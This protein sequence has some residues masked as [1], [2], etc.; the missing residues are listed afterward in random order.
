MTYTRTLIAVLAL[1]QIA[2]CGGSGGGSSDPAPLPTPSQ[3][4]A[5][6]SAALSWQ[7]PTMN[8]DGTVLTDL[9]G[10]RVYQGSNAS[11]S[12]MTLVSSIDNPSV[13]DYLV[14]NLAA[15]TYYFSVTSISTQ[16][17]ESA[18]SNVVQ[19]TID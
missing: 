2:A 15:G 13:S 6:G 17:G 18:Y 16:R 8:N 10:F 1:V 7:I 19:K 11:T 4:G 9:S 3:G 14:E 5:T 12:T